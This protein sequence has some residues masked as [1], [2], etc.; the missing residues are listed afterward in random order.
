MY[1][2]TSRPALHRIL[3]TLLCCQFC[4]PAARKEGFNQTRVPGL[5]GKSCNTF[6]EWPMP[7]WLGTVD[8]TS[9]AFKIYFIAPA[10]ANKSLLM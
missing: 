4:F 1:S 8:S 5:S 3:K 9:K 7:A 6:Q 2:K 10:V